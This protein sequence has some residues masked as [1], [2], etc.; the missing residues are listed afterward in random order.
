M[1][2]L[3]EIYLQ[4]CDS[5]LQCL[6]INVDLYLLLSRRQYY[7]IFIIVKNNNIVN[8]N[9]I[10]HSRI[11]TSNNYKYIKELRYE[12]IKNVFRFVINS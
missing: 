8:I 3:F 6:L 5:K 1:F 4:F 10:N 12:I 11:E 9:L 7:F 2:L